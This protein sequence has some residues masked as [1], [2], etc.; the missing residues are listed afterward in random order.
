MP[1]FLRI[2]GLRFNDYVFSEPERLAA[3]TAP[4]C[5]GLIAVLAHDPAWAPKPFRPL[6]FAEFGNDARHASA[7]PRWLNGAIDSLYA[8]VLPMP[9]S[10]T[11]QRRQ[12]CREL[13]SAYNPLFQRTEALSAGETERK[14][15]L[16]EARHQEQH[17]QILALFSHIAKLLEPQPVPPRRPIGFRPQPIVAPAG[18]GEDLSY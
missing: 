9:F 16:L 7:C 18:S 13:I 17:A 15:E 4:A 12:L 14:L 10:T 6:Y 3:W 1:S 8:A 5:A 11:A 2:P